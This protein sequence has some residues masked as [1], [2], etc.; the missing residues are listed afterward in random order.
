VLVVTVVR[1]ILVIKTILLATDL[2]IFTPCLLQHAADLA[3]Q[4]H[5]KLIVA[6]AIEPL[7]TLGHALLHAYL[8]PETTHALT[9]TGMEAM[10]KEVKNQLI[11]SL[12]DEHID[13]GVDLLQ[14]GEVIVKTG[15]PVDVILNI[16][17]DK[18]ADLI[19]VG[20]NSPDVRSPPSLGSVAQKIL[21]CAKVPVYVVPNSPFSLHQT[22]AHNQMRLW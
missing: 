5:A 16:A 7:G 6:H 22:E 13:G 4:H 18:E 2:S 17:D 12:A 9:T 1:Y 8:K 21:N 10:V 14:L 20:N 15:N 19:V 3:K 11:D